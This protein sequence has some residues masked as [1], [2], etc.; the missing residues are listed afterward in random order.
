M[1]TRIPSE[2]QEVEWI[3]STG[4]QWIDSGKFWE[5]DDCIQISFMFPYSMTNFDKSLFGCYANGSQLCE[6]NI[7]SKYFRFDVMTYSSFQIDAYKIYSISKDGN[8]WFVDGEDQNTNTYNATITTHTNILFGRWYDNSATKLIKARVYS[9]KQT[10][11]NVLI[12]NFIPCYRKSDSTPGMYDTISKTFFTNAGTGTFL[13]GRD[14]TYSTVNLLES[15]RRILLNT[16]HIESKSSLSPLS[17]S[18]DVVTDL[19]ECKVHFDPVQEGT[20]TPSPENVRE[21]KGWDGIEVTRCGKN[22]VNIFGYSAQNVN[23]KTATRKLTNNYG[24]TI[25]TTDFSLPDTPL[26]ITQSQ[27]PNDTTYHYKN[28]YICI[29]V[30]NLVFE[31]RYNV[32]FRITNI[33]NNPL[34]VDISEIRL[35]SLNSGTYRGVAIGDRLC[36]NNVLFSR[37]TGFPD[38]SEFEIRI[39]GMSFTLSE[40]MVTPVEDEDYTYAPY[41]PDEITISFPQTI[42]GG[43]LDLKSGELVVDMAMVDLGTM[44]W[45]RYPQNPNVYYSTSIMTQKAFGVENMIAEMFSVSGVAAVDLEAGRMRGIINQPYVYFGLNVSSVQEFV[46][47]VDGTKLI[48]E[49]ATPQTYQL[50]PETIRALKGINNVFSNANGN[51]GVKFYSH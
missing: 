1:V 13:V 17:F 20:G 47:A 28:G 2:Y 14:V 15:R 36:F 8:K 9:Y 43:T 12:L 41:D 42:Y 26:V 30:D 37:I 10:R 6:L 31:K 46:A 16:P 25:S 24:T 11:N 48:Y 50:T 39:C 5:K 27:W 4:T 33:T 38:K 7:N 21:I 45:L 34:N 35:L 18:T 19:K 44:T 22:I 3:E 40:F 49:L 29:A 51:I 32:S 23:S